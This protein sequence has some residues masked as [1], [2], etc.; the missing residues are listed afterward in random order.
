[1]RCLAAAAA[2]D[3]GPALAAAAA[4]AADCLPVAAMDLHAPPAWRSNTSHP[5]RHP[6]IAC[7]NRRRRLPLGLR[8]CPALTA[9]GLPHAFPPRLDPQA[10]ICPPIAAPMIGGGGG[11]EME[12]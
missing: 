8:P 11:G 6:T 1:M 5:Q 12:G 3:L 9:G 7:A 2:Y 10:R 4:A